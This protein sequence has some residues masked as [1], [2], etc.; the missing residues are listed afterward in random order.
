MSFLNV[1]ERPLTSVIPVFIDTHHIHQIIFWPVL[2][3][4]YNQ[5]Y[6]DLY[7]YW[8][9]LALGCISLSVD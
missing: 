4:I 7:H 5:T 2:I 8:T 3:L 6:V 9:E 1:D